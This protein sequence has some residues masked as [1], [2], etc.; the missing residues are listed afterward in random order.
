MSLEK[1]RTRVPGLWWDY[2][3]FLWTS[4][5]YSK[6]TGGSRC[7]LPIYERLQHTTPPSSWQGYYRCLIKSSIWERPC[8]SYSSLHPQY[9][10]TLLLSLFSCSVVSDS[11]W[12]RGLQHARPPCPSLSPRV[13]SNSCPL[14]QWCHPTISSSAI[15]FSFCLQSFPASESFPV[16]QLSHQVAKVLE[17]QLQYPSFQWILEGLISFRIDWF[18]LLAVQG[19]LKN[20]LQHHNSSVFS[21]LSDPTLTS[22]HNYWKTIALTYMDL[23]WQSDVSAFEYAF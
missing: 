22:I 14:S 3:F 12:P 4:F 23:G 10:D 21:L 20:I 16:S 11:L 17:L 15:C 1:E 2:F 18:V 7:F 5:S 19:T 8:L 9:R 6:L 13:C